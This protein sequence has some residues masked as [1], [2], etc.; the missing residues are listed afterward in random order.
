MVSALWTGFP[1]L[2]TI[3]R[4]F[5]WLEVAIGR[6]EAWKGSSTRAGAHRA[7]EFVKG[8]YPGLNLD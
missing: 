4:T 6:I 3:N 2:R 1:L 8:W 7:L 5:D